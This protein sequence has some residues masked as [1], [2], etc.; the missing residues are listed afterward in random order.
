MKFSACKIILRAF[1][2]DHLAVIYVHQK[3]KNLFSLS[4][5]VQKVVN[6]YEIVLRMKVENICK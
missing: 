6:P 3:R 1:Q 5:A 4:I 2:I